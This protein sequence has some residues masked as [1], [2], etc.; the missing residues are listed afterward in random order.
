[1]DNIVK[2]AVPEIK[3]C[4]PGGFFEDDDI[5]TMVDNMINLDSASI[6]QELSNILDIT[7]REVKKFIKEFIERVEK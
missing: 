2:W 1:M 5:R 3:N 6:N 7:Q 4:M